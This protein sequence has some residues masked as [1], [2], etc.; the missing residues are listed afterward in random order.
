[1]QSV[2]KCTVHCVG[3]PHVDPGYRWN[4]APVSHYAFER[5]PNN[6]FDPNAVKVVRR[7]QENRHVGYVAKEFAKDVADILSSGQLL[8]IIYDPNTSNSHRRVLR[9][10]YVSPALVA[11]RA[12]VEKLARQLNE[13]LA[14]S[15]EPPFVGSPKKRKRVSFS[16]PPVTNVFEHGAVPH[17]IPHS[18]TISHDLRQCLRE[19]LG[20]PE[21]VDAPNGPHQKSAPNGKLQGVGE[22][23]GVQK[24]TK[25]EKRSN[26]GLKARSSQ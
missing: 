2:D 4:S 7:D 11:E 3:M 21:H 25:H 10:Q 13:A 14:N 15:R 1:M 17:G 20:E 26:K 19:G 24:N 23:Q 5:E 9:L 18:G 16:V 8:S 22:K 6:R 12:I